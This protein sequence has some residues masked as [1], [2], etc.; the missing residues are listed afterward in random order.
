MNSRSS[1][2]F[3]A[4]AALI[5]E[6]DDERSHIARVLHD[7]VGQTLSAAGLQ[8]AV[9]Q[10]DFADRIPELGERTR[11]IQATLEQVMKSV[12]E[13]SHSVNPALAERTGLRYALEYLVERASAKGLRA[14]LDFPESTALPST[15]AVAFFR[16]A[17]QALEMAARQGAEKVA[18]SFR[19][20]DR[21]HVLEIRSEGSQPDRRANSAERS[22]LLLHHYA[23]KAGI[24]VSVTPHCE[25][26]A[27]IRAER[28]VGEIDGCC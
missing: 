3:E 10:L 9:L 20:A 16:V 23:L 11:E 7:E 15:G 4:V 28:V 21:S 19:R 22:L 17:E 25:G 8:L 13:L 6:F 5:G 12:R 1:T 27:V 18:V 24:V 26:G 14:T 2:G